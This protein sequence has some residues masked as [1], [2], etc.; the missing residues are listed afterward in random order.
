MNAN[1]LL[2]PFL[3]QVIGEHLQDLFEGVQ[4]PRPPVL[5]KPQRFR[6]SEVQ[7]HLRSTQ[8]TVRDR[9]DAGPPMGLTDDAQT[10]EEAA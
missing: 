3:Y 8:R 1:P 9:I 5:A 10:T 7:M 2:D 4:P 6:M